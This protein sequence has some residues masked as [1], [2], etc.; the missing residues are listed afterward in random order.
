MTALWALAVLVALPVTLLLH[1]DGAPP[2]PGGRTLLGLV[3]G[4]RPAR[5]GRPGGLPGHRGRR[6][7]CWPCSSIAGLWWRH[8][9]AGDR[10]RRAL[11]WLL[12]G[13]GVTTLVALPVEFLL[14]A[15]GGTAAR[16]VRDVIVRCLGSRPRSHWWSGR[17]TR[18][19]STS[20][21]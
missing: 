3:G 20:G 21:R 15:D 19:A 12:L 1:P 8:E 11:L 17:A 2:G 16:P 7:W 13:L 14:G 6:R 4:D 10:E 9:H 18:I 5:A